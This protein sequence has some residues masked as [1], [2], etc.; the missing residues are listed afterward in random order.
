[1]KNFNIVNLIKRTARELTL[2]MPKGKIIPNKRKK[3]LDKIRK[4]E[5]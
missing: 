5:F 3:I 4:K 2:N 1:M